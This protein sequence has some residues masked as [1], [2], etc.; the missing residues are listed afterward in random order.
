L[1]F[2]K[3]LWF[4]N[5]RKKLHRNAW[6]GLG[7]VEF[8][9]NKELFYYFDIDVIDDNSDDILWIKLSDKKVDVTYYMSVCYLP[10]KY[11]TRNV[12]ANMFFLIN[13]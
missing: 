11:S 13:C 4:G 3:Y 8:L 7:G 6:S 12:D 1:S 9:V 5:N 10:P 2:D